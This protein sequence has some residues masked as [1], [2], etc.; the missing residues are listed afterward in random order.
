MTPPKPTNPLPHKTEQS[1][2]TVSFVMS[3]QN[4][5]S[6]PG[7]CFQNHLGRK[8]ETGNFF[9]SCHSLSFWLICAHTQDLS[10][11]CH[12]LNKIYM[13]VFW[14]SST[15]R[16][17]ET[18]TNVHFFEIVPPINH[19]PYPL[20]V[21]CSTLWS[22]IL[23]IFIDN[24]LCLFYMQ[25]TTQKGVYQ[26][27]ISESPKRLQLQFAIQHNVRPTHFHVNSG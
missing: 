24:H 25:S 14:L 4:Q 23:L 1:L 3:F 17:F 16:F 19:N 11:L 13:N 5:F 10:P 26:H 12:T 7:V 22:S 18:I 21:R 8:C 27:Q 6:A 15:I 2:I 9:L 20:K